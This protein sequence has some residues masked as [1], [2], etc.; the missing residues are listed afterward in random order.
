MHHQRVECSPF[1]CMLEI[2]LAF[3]LLYSTLHYFTPKIKLNWQI[4]EYITIMK[5]TFGNFKWINSDNVNQLN[6]K[7]IKTH[8][9]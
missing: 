6:S 9:T 5:C 7:I 3:V 2:K 4:I 8:I 1:P